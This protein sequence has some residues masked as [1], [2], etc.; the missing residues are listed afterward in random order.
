MDE[1][2]TV[3]LNTEE[4]SL[5]FLMVSKCHNDYL[6]GAEHLNNYLI[7]EPLSEEH[8]ESIIQN[9]SLLNVGIDGSKSILEK[10]T[11]II[12]KKTIIPKPNWDESK[13]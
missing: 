6:I 12:E 13:E 9:I 1:K 11:R 3:V 5:L 7:N 10:L 2:H 8:K 4:I